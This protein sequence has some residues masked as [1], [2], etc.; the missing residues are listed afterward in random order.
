V[1]TGPDPATK[2]P[3]RLIKQQASRATRRPAPT[4]RITATG[5]PQTGKF[6][7]DGLAQRLAHK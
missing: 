4:Y 6:P 1:L 7:A 5:G 2:A 3:G